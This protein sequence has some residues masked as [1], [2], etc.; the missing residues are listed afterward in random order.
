MPFSRGKRFNLN[1]KKGRT[2]FQYKRLLSPTNLTLNSAFTLWLCFLVQSCMR[3]PSLSCT[4]HKPNRT[5]IQPCLNKIL[6]KCHGN[7]FCMLHKPFQKMLFLKLLADLTSKQ[8]QLHTQRTEAY[9][10]P[11]KSR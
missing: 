6:Q 8:L 11:L 1:L 2:D 7:G 4:L 3:S 9:K 5:L 10:D